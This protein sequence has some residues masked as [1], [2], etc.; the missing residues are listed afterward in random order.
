MEGVN[1]V[2][3]LLLFWTSKNLNITSLQFFSPLKSVLP[4]AK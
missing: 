2:E 4:M 3:K 1:I